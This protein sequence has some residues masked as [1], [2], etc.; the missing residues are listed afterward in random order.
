MDTWGE[1]DT[2]PV[3]PPETFVLPG[4]C[5]AVDWPAEPRHLIEH[6]RLQ[7]DFAKIEGMFEHFRYNACNLEEQRFSQV[8]HFWSRGREKRKQKADSRFRMRCPLLHVGQQTA[9]LAGRQGQNPPPSLL[10]GLLLAEVDQESVVGEAKVHRRA[11][12]ENGQV[13]VFGC[14]RVAEPEVAEDGRS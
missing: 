7:T 12:N 8:C 4:F 9:R 10:V 3:Q 6:L 2:Y 5:Q 14:E 13:S 1:V 11:P